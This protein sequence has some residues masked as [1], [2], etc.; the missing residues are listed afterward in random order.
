[1]NLKF[2]D[3][4]GNESQISRFSIGDVG[5]PDLLGTDTEFPGISQE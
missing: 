3:F 1:M 5:F 2:P 4:S